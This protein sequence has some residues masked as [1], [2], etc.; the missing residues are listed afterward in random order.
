[1][2]MFVG[3][4]ELRVTVNIWGNF[5]FLVLPETAVGVLLKLKL[6]DKF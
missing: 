2:T 1:M 4:M 6:N 5:F 3:T